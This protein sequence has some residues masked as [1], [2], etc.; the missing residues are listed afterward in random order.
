[1]ARIRTIKPQFWQSLTLAECST[2]ARLLFVAMLNFADDS[3]R[4]QWEPRLLKAFAFPYDDFS[5]SDVWEWMGE[6]HGA[7]LVTVY[8]AGGNGYKY[9][10]IN[11]FREHQ[12]IDR[13]SPSNIPAPQ[14]DEDSTNVRREFVESSLWEKEKEGKRKRKSREANSTNVRRFEPPTID[15]AMAYASEIE[16]AEAEVHNFHDH[17]QSNGWKVSGKTPMKDWK[18][19]MRKWQRN[20]G[21]PKGKDVYDHF[22]TLM[23]SADPDTISSEARAFWEHY[24]ATGWKTATGNKITNWQAKASE[25]I[26]NNR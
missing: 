6:L 21:G 19:A 8:T 20:N 3:G 11:S 26:R 25:W 13:P 2:N 9:A 10:Q 4:L 17:F 24:Q 14:F 15:E 7:D 1:M 12:R 22:T 23:P 16:M 5:H 18:A